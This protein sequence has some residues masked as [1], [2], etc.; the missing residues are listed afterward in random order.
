MGRR[1]GGIGCPRRSRAARL[2]SG[3]G[4]V[5][6]ALP[7]PAA[8]G[9]PL[10]RV[11]DLASAAPT[12]ERS[13]CR[14]LPAQSPDAAVIALRRIFRRLVCL[15]DGIR[16]GLAA[17]LHPASLHLD[18]AG[19]HYPVLDRE[20]YSTLCPLLKHGDQIYTSWEETRMRSILSRNSTRKAHEFSAYSWALQNRPRLTQREAALL[21]TLQSS[22]L[23]VIDGRN[24]VDAQ[25]DPRASFP[26]IPDIIA[27]SPNEFLDLCSPER[28]S[29]RRG[30]QI[31]P[32]RA[33]ARSA[34]R[35]EFGT[36][37]SE[38][39]G[40]GDRENVALCQNVYDNKRSYRAPPLASKN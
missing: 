19:N 2:Q 5:F 31:P 28:L 27:P 30:Y 33:G 10:S 40:A 17:H 24:N 9:I 14:G 25:N 15:G 16:T 20:K 12:P 26:F 36:E 29:C 37:G 3:G 13:P 39:G 4:L 32:A 7:L 34:I 21:H 18:V 23:P 1:A 8:H 6:S 35:R 22:F 38:S 11:R